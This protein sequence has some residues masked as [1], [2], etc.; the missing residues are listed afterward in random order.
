MNL[1]SSYIGFLVNQ[2]DA[3][4][5]RM[6]CIIQSTLKLAYFSETIDSAV[7][8]GNLKPNYYRLK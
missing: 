5:L 4:M 8:W 2:L 3:K 7:M 6:G 1:E